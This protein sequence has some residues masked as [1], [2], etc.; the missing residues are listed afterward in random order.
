M[1]E[2]RSC[3]VCNRE[4]DAINTG[5]R[6]KFIC[7]ACGTFIA[8]REFCDDTPSYPKLHTPKAAVIIGLWLRRS[9]VRDDPPVLANIERIEKL[10]EKDW[11]PDHSM[12]ADNLIRYIG[13]NAPL[14]DYADLNDEAVQFIV[15]TEKS[16]GVPFLARELAYKGLCDSEDVCARLKLQGWN[17]YDQIKRGSS[18]GYKAFMAMPFNEPD[19]DNTILPTAREAARSCGFQLDRVDDQPKPGIIDVQI[20]V[21]IQEAR[22]AIVDLT[23]EN[24]GAYWEAGYAEGMGKPVIY[25]VRADHDASVHFDTAHLRRVIWEPDK[26][27]LAEREIKA[28][29]RNEL[30]DAI[31]EE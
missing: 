3:I 17:V 28:M 6:I 2:K 5:E 26:L 14:G 1:E 24:L 21:A 7:P 4:A 20:R 9:Q 8:T 16:I 31:H 30:P 29:I 13:D 18:S 10:V 22:F 11:L 15:G 25:T 27:D 19:L 12:Q 23:Y